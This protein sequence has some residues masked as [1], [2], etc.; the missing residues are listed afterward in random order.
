MPP[1]TRRLTAI[2]RRP[3]SAPSRGGS[4]SWK[5]RGG[6]LFGEPALDIKDWLTCDSDGRGYINDM[7]C[8]QL[9][10]QPALYSTFLLWML[11]EVYDALPEVG[12][13]DKPSAGFFFDEAHLLFNDAP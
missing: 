5:P 12:D 9:F 3:V 4:F 11:S 7:N 8:E 13:P 1:D 6:E 2:F 10:Q